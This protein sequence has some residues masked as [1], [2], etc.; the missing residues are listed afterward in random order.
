MKVYILTRSI[1]WEDTYI[2]GVFGDKKKGKEMQNKEADEEIKD[3]PEYEVERYEGEDYES[4]K[5]A[6]CSY[7]LK[8][9]KVK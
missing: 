9:W 8:E 3:N 6:D 4:I 5:I 7:C 2:L 1:D